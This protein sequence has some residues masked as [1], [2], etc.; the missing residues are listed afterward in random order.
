MKTG[1]EI[2]VTAYLKVIST[3]ESWRALS[4]LGSPLF[5]SPGSP[6]VVFP[7]FHAQHCGCVQHLHAGG[8]PASAAE[9]HRRLHLPGQRRARQERHRKCLAWFHR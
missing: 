6:S 2:N 4:A 3:S 8:A 1:Y 9:H 7:R 5:A